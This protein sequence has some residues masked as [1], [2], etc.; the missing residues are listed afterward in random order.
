MNESGN[1]ILE[2]GI[3]NPSR[4][5]I[6]HDLI[7]VLTAITAILIGFN[8]SKWISL[9]LI[10]FYTLKRFNQVLEGIFVIV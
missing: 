4:L 10:I 6:R 1:N 7:V 5:S 3:S 8:G 2:F 9:L